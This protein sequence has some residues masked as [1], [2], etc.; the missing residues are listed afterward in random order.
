MHVSDITDYLIKLEREKFTGQVGINFHNGNV[1]LRVEK[2]ESVK[3]D[4]KEKG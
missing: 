1:C 3:L 2:K 4:K